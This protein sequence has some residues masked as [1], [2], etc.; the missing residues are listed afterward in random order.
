MRT[1]MSITASKIAKLDGNNDNQSKNVQ[2][3]EE[4]K[5]VEKYLKDLDS[6]NSVDLESQVKNMFKGKRM[7][8]CD[9]SIF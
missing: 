1:P 5:Y 3:L 7:S 4:H 9:S 8:K 6:N 2:N